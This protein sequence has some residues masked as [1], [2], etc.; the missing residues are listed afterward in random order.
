MYCADP[1]S[2]SWRYLTEHPDSA[3]QWQS[4]HSDIQKDQVRSRRTEVARQSLS[5]NQ[6]ESLGLQ[7]ASLISRV[8]ISMGCHP[9]RTGRT[10]IEVSQ[11]LT[12]SPAALTSPY[13]SK[14]ISHS[15]TPDELRL[16]AKLFRDL[17]ARSTGDSID[18]TTFLLFFPLPVKA[19]LGSVG[20]ASL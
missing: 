18:K 11:R 10:A 1:L 5:P 2:V 19:N 9:T 8:I 3:K 4:V 6:S 13:I 12:L 15:V 20:R 17:A 14:C 7:Q 16:I